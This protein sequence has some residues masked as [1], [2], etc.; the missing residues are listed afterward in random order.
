MGH[1]GVGLIRCPTLG[2]VRLHG[3]MRWVRLDGAWLGEVWTTF[4]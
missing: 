4:K 1:Q 3:L 2:R